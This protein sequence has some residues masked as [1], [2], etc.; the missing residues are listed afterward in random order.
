MLKNIYLNFQRLE[1]I[2]KQYIFKSKKTHKN[3]ITKKATTKRLF[4]GEKMLFFYQYDT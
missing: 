2:L 3:H 4:I 1:N